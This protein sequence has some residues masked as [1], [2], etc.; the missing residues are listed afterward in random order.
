M[1]SIIT[2]NGENEIN[3]LIPQVYGQVDNHNITPENIVS[4]EIHPL[5]RSLINRGYSNSLSNIL[6]DNFNLTIEQ[7]TTLNLNLRGSLQGLGLD[8]LG[9]LTLAILE[10]NEH[11][12]N[13]IVDILKGYGNA[14]GNALQ[15]TRLQIYMLLYFIYTPFYREFRRGLTHGTQTQRMIASVRFYTIFNVDRLGSGHNDD[16]D[17]RADF[18]VN[19][20][21]QHQYQVVGLMDGHGR[22]M[23]RILERL[24]ARHTEINLENI[25]F[26]VYDID[27]PNILYHSQTCIENNIPEDA[28]EDF[29]EAIA[30]WPSMSVFMNV[31]EPEVHEYMI[32]FNGFFYANFSGL[33]T[34][35]NA[36]ILGNIVQTYVESGN[37]N[38]I[39]VSFMVDMRGVIEFAVE[40]Y[41]FLT[42]Q[43]NFVRITGREDFVTLALPL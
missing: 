8:N 38:R 37:G 34:R 12:A 14:T 26:R 36:E 9:G 13:G 6:R 11:I 15:G 39:I 4:L 19:N 25:I 31:L 28:N 35:E 16:L 7:S 10:Q 43:C 41:N 1:N 17:T 30:N 27:I 29:V 3:D 5:I 40:L 21:I 33:H 2:W 32:K 22:V 23:K 24:L 20:I 18:I 42:S